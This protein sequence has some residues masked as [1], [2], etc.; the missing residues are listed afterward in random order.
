MR[1]VLYLIK[2]TI[3]SFLEF[4]LDLFPDGSYGD[5]MRGFF[6][7][8][9]IKKCGKKLKVSKHV[10]LVNS[11]NIIIGDNVY[12]GYGCWI[13][14]RFG[15]VIESNVMFGPYVVVTSS[16]HTFTKEK[17][18][19]YGKSVGKEVIIGEGSWLAAHSVVT[20][21]GG[22]R[23][24]SLLGANTVACKKYTDNSLIL[25]VCGEKKKKINL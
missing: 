1:K 5:R 17:M 12:I 24:Y 13:Q 19:Y 25:G 20:C 22:V 23:K 16:N 10:R 8:C 11:E 15:V 14:A 6:V 18:S 21:S 9:R 2:I 7:K 4:I 3:I